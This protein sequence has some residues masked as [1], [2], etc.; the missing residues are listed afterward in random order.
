MLKKLLW[1]ILILLM[2]SAGGAVYLH[3]HGELA[4]YSPELDGLIKAMDRQVNDGWEATS[5]IRAA[6]RKLTAN[7]APLKNLLRYLP[8]I[9]EARKP[10]PGKEAPRTGLLDVFQPPRKPEAAPPETIYTWVDRRGVRH[11]SSTRPEDP[12][13]DVEIIRR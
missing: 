7:L 6:V 2:V 13:K 9:D 8:F 10:P 4:A 3:H 11:F 5:R 1:S 12:R